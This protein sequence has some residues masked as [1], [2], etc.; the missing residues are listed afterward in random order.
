MEKVLSVISEN[1][2]VVQKSDSKQTIKTYATKEQAVSAA[3]RIIHKSR[4]TVVV[5]ERDNRSTGLI[6]FVPSDEVHEFQMHKQ[7]KSEG[8]MALAKESVENRKHRAEQWRKWASSH[9][10]SSLGLSD[11]AISRESMYG[12][13]G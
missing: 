9:K 7:L 11:E 3:R 1:N 5:Y 8:E 2:W 4:N 13:R 12:D 6:V 10:S